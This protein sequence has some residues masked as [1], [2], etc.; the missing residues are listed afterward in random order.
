MRKFL[1]VLF[2]LTTLSLL[3]GCAGT[4]TVNASLGKEFTL[5]IGKTANISGENLS[6]KFVDVTADSRCPSDVQC[7]WA[8]E[9]KVLL[10]IT[11][12]GSYQQVEMTQPGL[13][14]ARD[15][16]PVGAYTYHFSVEPYPISTKQIGK[17]DYRLKMTVSKS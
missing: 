8:G 9:V 11:V 16:Q 3:F 2:I 10:G 13:V 14:D 4:S 1:T 12:N 7:V 15:G 17:E 6:I 5:A